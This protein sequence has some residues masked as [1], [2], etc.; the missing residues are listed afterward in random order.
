MSKQLKKSLRL[1]KPTLDSFK[2]QSFYNEFGET[3][4]VDSYDP[5]QFDES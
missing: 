1:K 2:D 3:S 5:D 4:Y